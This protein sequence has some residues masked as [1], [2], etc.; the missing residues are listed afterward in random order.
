MLRA[1]TGKSDMSTSTAEQSKHSYAVLCWKGFSSVGDFF[2]FILGLY[3][4]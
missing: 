4:I 1:A 3:L 2:F